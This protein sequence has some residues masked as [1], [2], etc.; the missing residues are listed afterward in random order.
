M[1]TDAQAKTGTRTDAAKL[2]RA[3]NFANEYGIHLFLHV[4]G[5]GKTK[6]AEACQAADMYTGDLTR[7]RI[8][9]VEQ[10][11]DPYLIISAAHALVGPTAVIEPYD[12]T[13]CDVD[14]DALAARVARQLD[15]L[16]VETSI[17]LSVHAGAKYVALLEKAA[18]LAK[19][20]VKVIVAPMGGGV[21]EQKQG[22]KAWRGKVE[23]ART[24]ARWT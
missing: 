1:A 11:I 15:G 9:L 24:N 8:A 21:G 17:T 23:R 10:W 20:D 13:I 12:T 6:Q 14:R 18:A 19:T 5:C 22:Y 3:V 7:K 2:G 16:G 4:V